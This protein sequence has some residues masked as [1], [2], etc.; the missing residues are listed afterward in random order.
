MGVNSHMAMAKTMA[1]DKIG[2]EDVDMPSAGNNGKTLAS[3][4]GG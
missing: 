2:K 3:N 1:T 4:N